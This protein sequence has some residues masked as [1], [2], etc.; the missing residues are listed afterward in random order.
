[1]PEKWEDLLDVDDQEENCYHSKRL[2]LY[3]K[4]HTNIYENFKIIFRENGVNKTDD[5]ENCGENSD[6]AEIP[7]TNF[8]ESIGMK[9]DQS[10]DPFED[11]SLKYP[12]GFTPNDEEN[13]RSVHG[14]KSVNCNADEN[15]TGSDYDCVNLGSKGAE[16]QSVRFKK[17][18]A[19]RTGVS[20]LGLY[21]DV[22]NCGSSS[23]FGYERQKAK[24]KW[25]VEGDENTRFFHGML[26][27]KRN[28][29]NIRGRDMECLR[30]SRGSIL[31]NDSPTE[32]F[33][34]FKVSCSLSKIVLWDDA[35]CLWD[36][37]VLIM[38]VNV[39][40]E[41]VKHAASKLGCLTLKSPFLYL[42][43]KWSPKCPGHF[44][45]GH[46]LGS[47]KATWVKWSR[48]LTAIDHG[49]LGVSSLYA[50]NRVEAWGVYLRS[51][52]WGGA[53]QISTSTLSDMIS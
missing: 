48:V 30:S 13:D 10:D 27:K 9:E 28:P 17:S 26:N 31:V 38:G 2:C 52:V 33:Q 5:A 41:K 14:D 20:F 45:N 25:A 29:E 16:S 23:C 7:E 37:G 44:F 34:F 42:G 21:E 39:E 46:E 43:T 11:Q 50:L 22:V 1:M 49:G 35:R 36:Y 24:I 12:P 19:P 47:N 8:D 15:N 51:Y 6:V 32:E 53:D 18:E 4:M 3:T 40:D